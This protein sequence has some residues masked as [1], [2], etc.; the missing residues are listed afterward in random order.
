MFSVYL[1]RDIFF[2]FVK[3]LQ[4][5]CALC[6]STE[7]GRPRPP[8]TVK[9]SR[10]EKSLAHL[11]LKRHMRR[12]RVLYRR[13]LP[14]FCFYSIRRA[15]EADAADS[16]QFPTCKRLSTSTVLYSTY[17]TP[18]PLQSALPIPAHTHVCPANTWQ[19]SS[20]QHHAS[21][22]NNLINNLTKRHHHLT[23]HPRDSAHRSL[24][25]G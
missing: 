15:H 18:P 2:V 8:A 4:L 1:V 20:P 13:C 14:V 7:M 25:P 19:P 24:N 6:T 12:A 10:V 5:S 11:Q 21:R 16:I 9:L 22:N 3:M 17:C 23:S